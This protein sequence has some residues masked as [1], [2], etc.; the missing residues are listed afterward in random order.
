M[1]RDTHPHDG[2]G[3]VVVFMVSMQRNVFSGAETVLAPYRLNHTTTSDR[4]FNCIASPVAL[5]DVRTFL[6]V[7]HIGPLGLYGLWPSC[8]SSCGVQCSFWM[9]LSVGSYRGSVTRLALIANPISTASVSRELINRLNQCAYTT[10]LLGATFDGFHGIKGTTR[11]GGQQVRDC[12]IQWG[13]CRTSP[14]QH[15]IEL[16]REGGN[17]AVWRDVGAI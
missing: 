2:K 1:T 14:S 12:L 7:L 3:L 13:K 5:P 17:E 15:A 16:S 11:D 10:L 6:V 9:A 4:V 8:G